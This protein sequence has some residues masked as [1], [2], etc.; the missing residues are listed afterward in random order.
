MRGKGQDDQVNEPGDLAR[1]HTPKAIDD[2]VGVSYIY[3][4]YH[5]LTSL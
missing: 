2:Y 4:E 5:I 3:C 1:G